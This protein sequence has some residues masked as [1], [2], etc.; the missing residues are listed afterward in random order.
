MFAKRRRRLANIKPALGQCFVGCN[1]FDKV[2][3]TV[4]A[5]LADWVTLE[6]YFIADICSALLATLGIR[7]DLFP[8]QNAGLWISE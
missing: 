3:F 7:V 5:I 1:L 6:L 8:S 2:L 4:A